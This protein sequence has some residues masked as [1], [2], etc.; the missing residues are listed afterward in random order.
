MSG[1]C[2]YCRAP[3]EEG[4]E[5]VTCIG[6][7]TAHHA[8]CLQENGGCTV[9]GCSEAPGEEPKIS[10]SALEVAPAGGHRLPPQNAPSFL[11]LSGPVAPILTGTATGIATGTAAETPATPVEPPAPPSSPAVLPP[12]TP[13][14]PPPR[15]A[16]AAPPPPQPMGVLHS[17]HVPTMSY[18]T[19]G[20]YAAPPP[21]ISSYLPRKSRVVF[22]LLAVFLGAFGV[23]N[24]YAGYVKMG[25]IQVC[26]TFFSCFFGAA[27]SWIW[28]IVE[29]CTVDRDD[30]GIA[31]V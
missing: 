3:F 27:V 11:N 9:F 15:P 18:P 31:F 2:P 8:D 22:V 26:L 16:G 28:A 21:Q 5:I 20:G 24:F 12:V 25:V 10:V 29:A 4:D 23:H 30:D 7:A 6:C 13:T 14:P 1:T 19:F 17:S